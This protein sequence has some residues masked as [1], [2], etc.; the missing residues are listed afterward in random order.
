MTWIDRFLGIVT[1]VLVVFMMSASGFALYT[2]H[3]SWAEF[4]ALWGTPFGIVIGY[5]FKG[6][7]L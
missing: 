5:W 7:Q 1:L 2:A 4:L 6:Q 3:V